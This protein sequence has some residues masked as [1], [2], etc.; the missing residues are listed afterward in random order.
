[1]YKKYNQNVYNMNFLAINNKGL[2]LFGFY[3]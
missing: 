3:T 1:M 2:Q